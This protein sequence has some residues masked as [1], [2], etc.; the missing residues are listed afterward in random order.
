[1]KRVVTI[2]RICKKSYKELRQGPSSKELG[3]RYTKIQFNFSKNSYNSKE[4]QIFSKKK[5]R[6][7]G[8]KEKR[9]IA[10]GL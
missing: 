2:E 10:K 1:M 8:L 6:E 7:K 5:N 3:G 4:M 9:R